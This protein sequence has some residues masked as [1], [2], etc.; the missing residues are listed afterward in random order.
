MNY[1]DVKLK[2]IL[3]ITKRFKAFV[4]FIFIL[5]SYST[6]HSQ[7]WIVRNYTEN[8]GLPTSVIFCL[9]RD[10]NG[11]V[12]VGHNKGVSR[13]D[14]INWTHYSDNHGLKSPVLSIS[15][16]GESVWAGTNNGLFYSK[17]SNDQINFEE[18]EY[19][20]NMS[21]P[22][23]EKYKNRLFI[24]SYNV[25][26]PLKKNGGLLY[27]ITIDQDSYKLDSLVLSKEFYSSGVNAIKIK[28]DTVV[29]VSEYYIKAILLNDG[30]DSKLIERIKLLPE[31]DIK[32]SV[33]FQNSVTYISSNNGLYKLSNSKI[34]KINNKTCHFLFVYNNKLWISYPAEGVL[35]YSLPEMKIE[36]K[37]SIKNGLANSFMHNSFYFDVDSSLWIPTRCGLTHLLSLNSNIYFEK[38]PVYSI[39]DCYGKILVGNENLLSVIDNNEINNIHLPYENRFSNVVSIEKVDNHIFFNNGRHL[40]SFNLK[41]TDIDF[42]S[43]KSWELKGRTPFRFSA[44]LNQ[45]E[46]LIAM[47]RGLGLYNLKDMKNP[48]Y[49][50]DSSGSYGNISGNK[51][52]P[53]N[54]VNSIKVTS[55]GA[56]IGTRSGFA[57]FN[58]KS[59]KLLI[60]HYL[61]DFREVVNDVFINGTDTLIATDKG[62]YNLKNTKLTNIKFNNTEIACYNIITKDSL[63]YCGTSDG[64][65]IINK[66]FKILRILNDLNW[67]P[68]RTIN[69]IYFDN[70][71]NLWIGTP[72]GCLCLNKDEIIKKPIEKTIFIH[73]IQEGN[74]TIFDNLQPKIV[75]FPKEVYLENSSTTIKLFCSSDFI[76]THKD[77]KYVFNFINDSDT[78]V[79]ESDIPY[80]ESPIMTSGNYKIS[81]RITTGGETISNQ[82]TLSVIVPSPIYFQWYFI[83]LYVILLISLTSLAIYLRTRK[84][85]KSNLMLQKEVELRVKDIK[86][87]MIEIDELSRAR[88]VFI[89]FFAHD[90]TNAMANLRRGYELLIKGTNPD[91]KIGKYSLNTYIM[92]SLRRITSLTKQVL[93]L[94]RIESNRIE[95]NKEWMN[96]NESISKVIQEMSFQAFEK[97]IK[98]KVDFVEMQ[99][100]FNDNSLLEFIFEN[101]LSNALKYSTHNSEILIKT[102]YFDEKPIIEIIDNGPGFK[103]EDFPM[104]FKPFQKLSAKPTQGESSTG[105]GLWIVKSLLE[106]IGGTIKIENK[107]PNGAL[108]KI[109]LYQI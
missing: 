72:S 78:L 81:V 107:E 39:L 45:N 6:L 82:E 64:V 106:L 69:K 93:M 44:F 58:Y 9:T 38:V 42:R 29:Y 86:A 8:D 92:M 2:N 91:K 13:F 63:I 98:I 74:R 108:V 5:L 54:Y 1:I 60:P 15:I 50:F 85:V 88:A 67:L 75:S 95:I 71:G 57:V 17:L 21:I 53:S 49:Y 109:I 31:K 4:V 76:L 83:L 19:F 79:F 23:I 34:E 55:D 7:S 18:F 43:L 101:I 80:F 3:K 52:L 104:M 20:K 26:M 22:Q 87:K 10:I 51:G 32:M 16:L 62:L 89:N 25:D 90:L 14:G 11:M 27:S 97:N 103:P 24:V 47:G 28:K 77:V 46:F 73:R 48:I 30:N 102:Y 36:R 84:I 105:L 41:R 12:W 65:Y 59:K 61:S 33:D 35:I 99:E 56:L 96:I 94:G 37:L 40:F 70:R 66:D 100:I 68:H